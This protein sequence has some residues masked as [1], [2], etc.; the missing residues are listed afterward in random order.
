MPWKM[1]FEEQI[2]GLLA[3]KTQYTEIQSILRV[4]PKRI[5]RVSLATRNGNEHP[6]RE[7]GQFLT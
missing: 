2:A 6:F 1:T 7:E 3:R 5:A 4:S